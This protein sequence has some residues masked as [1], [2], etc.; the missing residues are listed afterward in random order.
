[1][2]LVLSHQQ[3]KSLKEADARY[4]IW[5]GA[6][7]SGKTFASLLRFVE[8]CARGPDGD[9]AIIGKS[10]GA[11]KRNILQPLCALLGDRFQYFLG[12]G[13][14][15]VFHRTIHLIGA[16]DERAEHK[17][18]GS[19]FA[20]AYVDEITIIPESVFEMLKSRLS[21]PGAK[22]FGT[23]N[24]DSPF[25]WFKVKFLDRSSELDLKMWDFTLDDNPSLDPVFKENIRKE[26]QGLWFDRF[27][28]GKWVLAEGTVFDMFDRKRHTIDFPP[29]AADYYV[30]GVDYG[31][32]NPTAFTMIGYSQRTFPNKWL[33]KEYYWDSKRELRQKTDTEYCTDLK[34]FVAGYNVRSI[35]IDPSAASFK[36]ELHRANLS[37]TNIIEANNEVL[38]GI[39]YHAMN[40]SN[41]TFKICS[42]CTRTIEEYGSY[43]WDPRAALRGEDKPLKEHD[44]CLDSVRYALFTEW[45]MKEGPRMRPDD[46]DRLHAEALGIQRH[47][48]FFDDRGW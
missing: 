46:L 2:D 38:D 40:L 30:V 7:R 4:N 22:L 17:I 9:M 43:R 31:T 29:G 26:Y 6:V 41:G 1:M 35:Y 10:V 15:K 34:R 33:E 44:H 42:N 18:R 28:G 23:T 27:I 45:Y 37:P 32:T 47:G 20:G 39:R 21:I 48:Q 11:I 16:N 14:A 5:V 3:Q 36:L 12:K 8:F 19:S 24:P 25:H 13:E